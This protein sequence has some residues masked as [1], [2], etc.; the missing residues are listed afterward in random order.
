M[1][2]DY[3]GIPPLS[4][5][6]KYWDAIAYRAYDTDVSENFERLFSNDEEEIKMGF[7]RHSE[8]VGPF[9]SYSIGSEGG[10]SKTSVGQLNGEIVQFVRFAETISVNISK[11]THFLIQAQICGAMAISS[12]EQTAHIFNPTKGNPESR[13]SSED[14]PKL[15]F[16]LHLRGYCRLHNNSEEW[17]HIYYPSRYNISW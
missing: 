1:R 17:C 2:F 14:E 11:L 10:I 4:K 13:L 7:T 12:E 9:F 15:P 3:D 8:N 16:P 5:M 6:S